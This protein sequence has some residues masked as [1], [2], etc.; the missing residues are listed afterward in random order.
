MRGM[1]VA[2]RPGPFLGGMG[3]LLVA[4][5]VGVAVVYDD[6]IMLFIAAMGAGFIA[7]ALV[8]QRKTTG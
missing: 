6:W 2:S 7:M 8:A 1:T 5:G 3:A 4:V